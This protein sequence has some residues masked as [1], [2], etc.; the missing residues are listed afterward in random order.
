MKTFIGLT[1]IAVALVVGF[2]YAFDKSWENR[3]DA[4]SNPEL[5]P[6]PTS[7]MRELCPN[8]NF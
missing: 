8:H 6:N 4:Y 2:L 7:E 3:C 5:F 1:I